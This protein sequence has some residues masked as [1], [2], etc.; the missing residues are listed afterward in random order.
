MPTHLFPT[1]PLS[2]AARRRL[3]VAAGLSAGVACASTSPTLPPSTET[4]VVLN[5]GVGTLTILPITVPG[6]PSTLT[7]GPTSVGPTG[8]LTLGPIAVV[9]S[10]EAKALDVLDLTFRRLERTI[11]LE[12]A[13]GSG[14][15]LNDSVAYIANPLANVVT[16]VNVLSGDTASVAVGQAPVALAV[17]RGRIFVLNANVDPACEDPAACVLGASWISV[18]DP[19]R[20][21]V[22]DSVGLPGPGNG[23]AITVGGDGQVYALSAGTAEEAGRLSVVD[24]VSRTEVGSFGGFG[25]LPIALASDGRERLY[26]V[27]A[28]GLMEFNTRTRRV[29]RGAASAIPLDRGREAAVD[30]NGLVYVVESGSCA[31]PL[32][33]RIRVFRPDLTEARVV[34]AGVCAAAAGLVRLPPVPFD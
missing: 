23:S 9:T 12:H 25:I 14:G 29:V 6:P 22:T 24:P 10:A 30:G 26:V 28:T 32:Q 18:V 31:Y 8:L 3:V 1:G 5:E 21:I 34:T 17:A 16:Q 20:N 13:P 15:L 11:L 19:E 2:P 27:S 4:L 33:G 7:L